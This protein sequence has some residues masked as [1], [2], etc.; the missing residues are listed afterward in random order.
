MP[1]GAK[2]G[3]ATEQIRL[4]MHLIDEQWT[5]IV[6]KIRRLLLVCIAQNHCA[7]CSV[8]A[9]EWQQPSYDFY[10]AVWK[11]EAIKVLSPYRVESTLM[12]P[13]LRCTLHIELAQCRMY[14]QKYLHST[15]A[16][17]Q[18]YASEHF[19]KV[20]HYARM[21]KHK[22]VSHSHTSLHTIKKL[23]QC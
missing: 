16:Q 9:H 3:Q 8:K 11:F 4:L 19:R 13:L 6:H 18:Q 1:V 15:S 14:F 10:H 23:W 20:V 22:N 12:M 5:H 17:V 21:H 2:G 7:D